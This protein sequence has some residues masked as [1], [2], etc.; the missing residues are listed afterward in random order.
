M[1]NKVLETR[2]TKKIQC[3]KEIERLAAKRFADYLSMKGGEGTEEDAYVIIRNA[4][5]TMEL[6]RMGAELKIRLA[7]EDSGRERSKGGLSTKAKAMIDFVDGKLL[8]D[9]MTARSCVNA[10][11]YRIIKSWRNGRSGFS[12]SKETKTFF[13]KTKQLTKS[14]GVDSL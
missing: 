4:T 6:T 2:D 11:I 8:L 1:P 3:E 9:D 5:P 14:E 13:L 7:V 12:Y 10:A